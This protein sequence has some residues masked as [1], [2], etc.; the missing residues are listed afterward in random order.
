MSAART[1]DGRTTPAARTNDGRTTPA[2]RPDLGNSR[3]VNEVA[4]SL[5][6]KTRRSNS[7]LY[8][9]M[10]EHYDQLQAGREGRPDW[11]GA[12]E[13]LSSLG[14]TGRNGTP[15]RPNNVRKVWGRVVRDRLAAAKPIP[16][17]APVPLPKPAPPP[18]PAPSF[19]S[20]PVA[21]EFRT[22]R[23]TPIRKQE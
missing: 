19:T 21:F 8:R 22:L 20:E 1:D 10:Q 13:Q 12:T 15:L 6:G 17:A 16:A 3:P 11:I 7:E 2:A 4:A 18:L 5:S 9:W 23:K 14:M